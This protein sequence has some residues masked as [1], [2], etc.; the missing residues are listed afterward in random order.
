M[1]HKSNNWEFG[2]FYG[3]VFEEVLITQNPKSL[4]RYPYVSR[5]TNYNACH[6]YDLRQLR[7]RG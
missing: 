4:R 1:D 2:H 5:N 7:G 6:W 3:V